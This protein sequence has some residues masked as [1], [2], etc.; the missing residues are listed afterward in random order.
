MTTTEKRLEDLVLG[1]TVRER[2]LL[3][4]RPWLAGEVPAGDLARNCPEPERQE[5]ERLFHAIDQGVEAPAGGERSMLLRAALAKR[6]PDRVIPRG[7]AEALRL[8]TLPRSTLRSLSS[9]L[10]LPPVPESARLKAFGNSPAGSWVPQR[11]H[12]QPL[13]HFVEPLRF[14]AVMVWGTANGEAPGF[15]RVVLPLASERFRVLDRQRLR[16]RE[17]AAQFGSDDGVRF[18]LLPALL[19]GMPSSPIFASGESVSVVQQAKELDAEIR[20]RI[21]SVRLLG[22]LIDDVEFRRAKDLVENLYGFGEDPCALA[23]HL[24][25]QTVVEIANRHWNGQELWPFVVGSAGITR[26]VKG[27]M[28]RM[29]LEQQIGETFEDVLRNTD[30]PTF[31]QLVDQGAHRFLAPILAHSIVPR[32]LVPVLMDKVIAPTL[33]GGLVTALSVHDLQQRFARSN[34]GLPRTLERFLIHGGAVTRELVERLIAYVANECQLACG[35]PAWLAVEV[36]NWWATRRLHRPASTAAP[37]RATVLSSP[38]LQYDPEAGVIA[39]S[40]P[41]LETIGRTWVITIDALQSTYAASEPLWRREGSRRIVSIERPP[42]A[43]RV[44]LVNDVSGTTVRGWE[45]P[46]VPPDRPVLFFGSP[47]GR[48]MSSQDVLHGDRWYIA[49]QRGFDYGTPDGGTARTLSRFGAPIGWNE[50]EVDEVEVS[51]ART[52]SVGTVT[53]RVSNE[54]PAARIEAQ[55]LP[56]Y[57][58]PLDADILASARELPVVRLPGATGPG[59]AGR[60]EFWTVKCENDAGRT[61]SRTARQLG[62]VPSGSDWVVGLEGLFPD[63]TGTWDVSVLGRLGEGTAARVAL[64]P[65]DWNVPEPPSE[66]AFRGR[67]RTVVVNTASELKALEPGDTATRSKSGDWLLADGSGNGRIPLAISETTAPPIT[68]VLLTLPTISWRW[69]VDGVANDWGEPR[70]FLSAELEHG[71]LLVSSDMELTPQ[72]CLIDHATRTQLHVETATG[73][74]RR[75]HF[76]ARAFSTTAR[77]ITAPALFELSVAPPGSDRVQTASVGRVVRPAGVTGLRVDLAGDN[78]LIFTWHQENAVDVT[79]RLYDVH[80]PWAEPAEEDTVREDDAYR[81][82]IFVQPGTYVFELWTDDGWSGPSCI[83]R[84][85]TPVGDGAARKRRLSRLP[86]TVLGLLER[87]IAESPYKDRCHYLRQVRSLMDDD[88]GGFPVEE[89]LAAIADMIRNDVSDRVASM[90]WWEI[91]GA[92]AFIDFDPAVVLA[93]IASPGGTTNLP[94]VLTALCVGRWRSLWKRRSDVSPKTRR[95]LW[96]TWAPLAAMFD[97]SD[98]RADAMDRCFHHLGLDGEPKRGAAAWAET[99]GFLAVGQFQKIPKLE[100]VPYKGKTFDPGAFTAACGADLE[101]LSGRPAPAGYPSFEGVARA[102]KGFVG[103]DIGACRLPPGAS[104]FETLPAASIILACWD[105]LIARGSAA[106]QAGQSTARLSAQVAHLVPNLFARDLCI[107]E[108][109]LTGVYGRT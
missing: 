79:T 26:F 12:T 25:S 76:P 11:R 106:D 109:I 62:G 22:E 108:A 32:G 58:R 98:L 88:P 81:S 90:P 36:D 92:L 14:V 55:S 71:E 97:V 107:A 4:I 54:T 53:A 5:M 77:A 21:R 66:A 91:G 20:E 63:A 49:R 82:D 13:L 51:A 27:P 16:P 89:L 83:H 95:S 19:L 17:V 15:S 7:T 3:A 104:P 67:E 8:G 84:S 29:A 39:V 101:L 103:W 40:L 59:A 87:S 2:V 6:Y 1:L 105:R 85:E 69:E 56:A 73:K 72:V 28:N 24:L 60:L 50:F 70:A 30:L 37:Q 64:L 10:L 48:A 96:E 52:L 61:V 45:L 31:S 65:L 100:P 99:V 35:L 102:V 57:L 80:R 94:E 74:D 44:D 42:S 34:S 86:R 43:L 38:T 46:S 68:N 18:G 9:S 93:A 23:P 78:R 47:G 41:Y 75:W 33:E